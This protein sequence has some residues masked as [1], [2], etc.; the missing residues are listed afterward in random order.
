MSSHLLQSISLRLFH[1]LLVT[2]QMGID[3]RCWC[4]Q[5]GGRIIMLAFF[6]VG[7]RDLIGNQHLRMAIFSVRVKKHAQSL[8][9]RF[10]GY[11]SKIS[12]FQ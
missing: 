6:H 8:L 1:L 2:S 5:L 10:Y 9:E 4:H 3:I 11:F 12:N 7:D